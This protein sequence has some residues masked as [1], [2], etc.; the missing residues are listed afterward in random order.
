MTLS[1]R[2]LTTLAAGLLLA[3]TGVNQAQANNQYCIENLAQE[4]FLSDIAPDTYDACSTGEI[5]ELHYQLVSGQ[6][7]YCLYNDYLGEYLNDDL[8]FQSTCDGN[9]RWI[10]VINGTFQCFKNLD[11]NEYLAISAVDHTLHMS[12]ACDT[13]NDSWWLE[14]Q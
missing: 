6:L 7:Y 13:A 14:L 3:G 5:W 11:S 9:A 1:Q 12:G 2:R 8:E 10:G 4:Q